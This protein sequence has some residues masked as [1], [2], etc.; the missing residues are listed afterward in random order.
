MARRHIKF[1]RCGIS[2]GKALRQYFRASLALLVA[3]ATASLSTV[4]AADDEAEMERL[5]QRFGNT[6]ECLKLVATAKAAQ[7]KLETEY[8]QL[9]V[10]DEQI[11]NIKKAAMEKVKLDPEFKEAKDKRAAAYR[12][13]QDYLYTN[14]AKL[15]ELKIQME[16][17]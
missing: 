4:S 11:N 7:A 5:R 6:P 15:G 13:Q 2:Q 16:L 12:A 9:F 1:G 3:S 14:D 8:P 17:K 10:S